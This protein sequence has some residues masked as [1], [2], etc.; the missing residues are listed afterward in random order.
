[1]RGARRT[2]RGLARFL[3]RSAA[4]S[5]AR[6]Q[7]LAPAGASPA[8]YPEAMPPERERA[9]RSQLH[10]IVWLLEDGRV[11]EAQEVASAGPWRCAGAE[12]GRGAGGVPG[13]D[14]AAA[15]GGAPV[16][17]RVRR[18]GRPR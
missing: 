10:V 13:P 16:E 9:V 4:V 11:I 8:G 2:I 3:L 1:M 7:H 14:S 18:S 15:A 17:D 12:A 5:A 6:E